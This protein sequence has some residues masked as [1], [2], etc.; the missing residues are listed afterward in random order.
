MSSSIPPK[1]ESQGWSVSIFEAQRPLLTEFIKTRV[2]P[3][4]DAREC[5]RILIRAPV[6][7]G[8]REMVE[9]LAVRDA[10]HQPVRVHAFVSAFHRVADDMQRKELKIHNMEVFSLTKKLDADRCVN[11]IRNKIYEGK[12]VV[13]HIDE[14]DF[15]SGER[16]TLNTIY[17]E[18]TNNPSATTILYSATPQE[19]LFSG[20]VETQENQTMI[21]EIMHTG[22]CVTYTPPTSFC[23][24]NRFLDENLIEEA[25]PFFHKQNN[26]ITLSSQGTQL[27]RELRQS[28]EERTGRNILVLRLSYSDLGGNVSDKKQNKAIHQFLKYWRSASELS[29]CIIVADKSEKDV[30][31]SSNI[32]L[33][34]IQW[35]NSTYWNLKSRDVPIIMVIDQ[36]SSRSTEWLCHNRVFAYHDFRN[37]INF[38]T[39]SQAQERVNHYVEKYNNTFQRIKVYGHYKSFLLSAGRIDYATYLHHDWEARKIDTR[40]AATE[41]YTVPMY[42]IRNTTNTNRSHPDYE[43]P[44]TKED[45]DKALQELGCFTEIKVSA[46]VKGGIARIKEYKATFYPCTKETFSSLKTRIDQEYNH[47]FQNPFLESERH[48]LENGKWKGQRRGWNVLDYEKDIYPKP[49]YGGCVNYRR[50]VICYKG[51][52]LGIAVC[53]DTGETKEQNT[54]AVYKSMYGQ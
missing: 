54:L 18:V 34:K 38:S 14:C 26:I 28:I 10:A 29:D 15:G 25:I 19:V 6:K 35:S 48:G 27:I 51:P 24:P 33:E 53:Y 44:L 49:G 30:P 21:D 7:S 5:R 2:L 31:T 41:G 9:Y 8:K 36:T 16:Q 22:E 47:N 3:L 20:D 37:T 50:S 23:G 12:Q 13:L 1:N 45:A 4:L 40:R 46:R 52:V 32:L 17:S 43:H 42:R 39:I 11:W